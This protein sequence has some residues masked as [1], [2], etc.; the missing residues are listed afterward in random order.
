MI[1]D[2]SLTFFSVGVAVINKEKCK[3]ENSR[4]P[5]VGGLRSNDNC[6][7]ELYIRVIQVM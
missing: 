3:T 1:L 5:H 6:R 4:C 7:G 2:V